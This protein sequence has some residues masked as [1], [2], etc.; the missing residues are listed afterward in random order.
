MREN[1][2]SSKAERQAIVS[3]SQLRKT[4]RWKVGDYHHCPILTVCPPAANGSKITISC[5]RSREVTMV[6]RQEDVAYVFYQSW[7]KPHTHVAL[8]FKSDYPNEAS[9]SA[10]AAV[11]PRSH[12]TDG[13]HV[14]EP[15]LRAL[16]RPAFQGW[17]SS[18]FRQG[19]VVRGR[20]MATCGRHN[21]FC[22]PSSCFDKP[23]EL[24]CSE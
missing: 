8:G 15:P 24:K 1:L 12:S 23:N 4:G 10:A 13:H 18:S 22:L 17:D 3:Y 6:G 19:G 16:S 20:K 21:G 11:L 9:L 2:V 7:H 14:P 5:M